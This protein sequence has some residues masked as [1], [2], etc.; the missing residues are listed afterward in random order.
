MV[1]TLEITACASITTRNLCVICVVCVCCHHRYYREAEI[2]NQAK[3]CDNFKINAI[4]FCWHNAEIYS[5]SKRAKNCH[6]NI[7]F[8]GGSQC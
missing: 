1:I 8:H 3:Y 4:F 7:I 2:L 5:V 6:R